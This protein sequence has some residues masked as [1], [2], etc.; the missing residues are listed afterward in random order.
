MNLE[1]IKEKYDGIF[2]A[3]SHAKVSLMNIETLK[4]DSKS[5]LYGL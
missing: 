5:V 4:K 2:L 1:N 3:V